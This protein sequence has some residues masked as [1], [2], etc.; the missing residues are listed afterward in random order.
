MTNFNGGGA[1]AS[2]NSNSNTLGTTGSYDD[3]SF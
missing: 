2:I 3:P 1:A